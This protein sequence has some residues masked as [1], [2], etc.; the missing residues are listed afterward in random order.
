M[1]KGFARRDVFDLFGGPDPAAGEQIPAR[2][3]AVALCW[4]PS[5]SGP[6]RLG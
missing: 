5:S 4:L 3:I 1:A 2:E 6:H